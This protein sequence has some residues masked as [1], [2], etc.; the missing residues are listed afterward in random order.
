MLFWPKM[1]KKMPFFGASCPGGEG[2][3]TQKESPMEILNTFVPPTVQGR[4]YVR[5]RSILLI[6][7]QLI[8]GA[9]KF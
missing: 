5:K 7:S 8:E 4:P 1:P 3:G 9:K 6:A 2:G